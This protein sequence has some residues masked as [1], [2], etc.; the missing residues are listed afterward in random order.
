MDINWRKLALVA[1]VASPP[2]AIIASTVE[3]IW[4]GWRLDR[5]KQKFRRI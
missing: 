3:R 4:S 5:D 2:S 1:G